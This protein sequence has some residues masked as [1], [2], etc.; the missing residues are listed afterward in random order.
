LKSRTKGYASLDYETI[1]YRQAI[2][3]NSRFCLNAEVVDALSF[4]VAR[5]KASSRGRKKV[6]ELIARQMFKVVIQAAIGDKVVARETVSAMRKNVLAKC[7][8]GDISRKRKLLEKQK[9]GKERMKRVGRMDLPQEAS[10]PYC[11]LKISERSLHGRTCTPLAYRPKQIIRVQWHEKRAGFSPRATS[12]WRLIVA[13]QTL[14]T[15]AFFVIKY[16]D[17]LPNALRRAQALRAQ[18]DSDFET[19]MDWFQLNHTGFGPSNLV[20]VQVQSD[21]LARNFGYKSDGTSFISLDSL[22]GAGTD[23]GDDAALALFIAEFSEILMSYRAQTKSGNW[24]AG[25]SQGE[26]LSVFCAGMMH[27]VGYYGA[28]LGP[29]SST[30]LTS[31]TRNDPAHNWILSNEL[32]DKDADSYSCALLF[33]YYLYS[34]LGYSITNIIVQGGTS[35]EQTYQNLTGG[36]GGDTAFKALLDSYYPVGKV[37][38]L[39]SDNP[40]PLLPSYG[41]RISLSFTEPVDGTTSVESAGVVVLSPYVGCP[42]KEY[43]YTISNTPRLLHGLATVTGF[44]EPKYAWTVNGQSFSS[45]TVI[46]TTTTVQI[47][48]P[49]NPAAP[50]LT[51]QKV[52][53]LCTPRTI[54]DTPFSMQG[55]LDMYVYGTP[56]HVIVNVQ[57]SVSEQF[58]GGGA[59]TGSKLATIDQRTLVYDAQYYEDR[60]RCEHAFWTRAREISSRY[61]HFNDIPIWK[62]LPDPP[63]EMV[64]ALAAVEQIQRA[65]TAVERENP[66]EGRLLRSMTATMLRTTPGMLGGK[67]ASAD[68]E[69]EEYRASPSIADMPALT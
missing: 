2:W 64:N 11:V 13:I 16:Q 45:A 42:P 6:K 32:S 28:N 24:S 1:G 56:G 31:T 25:N 53:I 7:Y 41:S 26:G 68:A 57:V 4:I 10:W 17:S 40:F 66:R 46:T 22:E 39:A 34:Q 8:G 35:L 59:A 27:P 62:T 54:A 43:G 58:A 36:S 19:I 50:T 48:N 30:W 21:T 69:I 18:V 61:A 9:A 5:E 47:D 52:Q 38:A 44:G 55:G 60:A 65:L 14:G 20:T 29:R 3:L 51:T 15:T 49:A 63:E 37:G 23:V 12:P 33:I 67:A